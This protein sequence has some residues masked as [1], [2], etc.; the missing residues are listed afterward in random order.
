MVRESLPGSESPSAVDER[1]RAA[2]S[3]RDILE[4]MPDA[5]TVFSR[6]GTIV[7]FKGARDVPT[8]VEPSAFIGKKITAPE[9]AYLPAA[10]LLEAIER[11]FATRETQSPDYEVVIEGASYSQQSTLRAINEGEAIWVARDVTHQREVLR[12]VR[13][14]EVNLRLAV[15]AARM[16]LFEW[17]I[18]RERFEWDDVTCQIYGVTQETM[19]RDRLSFRAL[20]HP[21]DRE[22]VRALTATAISTGVYLPLEHRIVRPDGK[23]RWTITRATVLHDEDGTPTKMLGGVLDVTAEREIDDRRRLS[24]KLESIGQ[25]SAGMAHNFN[26]LLMGILPNLE[27]ALPEVSPEVAELLRSARESALRAGE[28]VRQFMAY[29]GHG[30]SGPKRNEDVRQLVGRTLAICARAFDRSIAL[31][32]QYPEQPQVVLMAST[33]VEQCLLNILIN[34]R[35][36]LTEACTAS[37]SVRV[38]VDRLA[39]GSVEIA[40]RDLAPWRDYVRVQI[41]DNGPGMDDA[42]RPRIFDPFFTT[43]DPGHGTGLGLSTAVTTVREHGGAIDCVSE[44]GTGSVFSIYLPLAPTTGVAENVPSRAPVSRGSE[45][46][47]LVDDESAVRRVVKRILEAEGY[48]VLEAS[49]GHEALERL[50]DVSTRNKVALVLL[51]M[52]MPSMPGVEVRRRVKELSP[53]LRVAYFTGYAPEPRQDVDGVIS[54]PISTDELLLSVR[55]ILDRPTR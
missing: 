1:T 47:L 37:P 29:A 32:A 4:A 11:A 23:I 30:Q 46:I 36:A 33:Q 18:K 55:E 26:N 52:S 13:E 9:L 49:S 50:S 43:K 28:L 38:T 22:R 27:L 10:R 40:Q 51:D 21:E 53:T 25:L 5:I 54:K 41:T 24:Q 31:T 2:K 42:T 14:S 6:D 39:S 7:D 16:G 34:A 3:R 20:V 12:R 19:P 45:T 8:V 35:D 44:L 48:D 17:D 15:N